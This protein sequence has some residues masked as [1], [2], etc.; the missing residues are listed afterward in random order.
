MSLERILIRKS[1]PYIHDGAS[2]DGKDNRRGDGK[3]EVKWQAG[4]VDG[5]HAGFGGIFAHR[6]KDRINIDDAAVE[7][8]NGEKAIADDSDEAAD[9]AFPVK[10]QNTGKITDQPHGEHLK[11]G[12]CP[13]HEIEIG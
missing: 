1:H 4:K 7:N 12:P 10:K 8:Q 2:N 11:R 3:D 9:R 5:E 13:L 6:E